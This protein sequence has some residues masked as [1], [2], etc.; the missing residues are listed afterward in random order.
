MDAIRF[1]RER[2]RMCH[3]FE[4]CEGC[5]AFNSYNSNSW[6][7]KLV[8]IVEQWS[9]EH[10]RKTRQSEFLKQWPEA[11]IDE[12]GVL[13]VCP[14]ELSA[15]YRDGDGDCNNTEKLCVDCRHEFWMREVE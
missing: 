14:M 9:K 15:T 13:E 6:N 5:P 4:S 1:I 11:S 7:E 3:T 10:P 2:N 8:A 12:S